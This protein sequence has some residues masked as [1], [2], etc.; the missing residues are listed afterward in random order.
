[1]NAPKVHIIIVNYGTPY[2]TLE[3]LD[4][5]VS[6]D[7][8][9]YQVI[10]VDVGNKNNSKK[11][12]GEWIEKKPETGFTLLTEKEN[13]GFAYANN[14]GIRYVLKQKDY[15][16]IWL[17]NNDTVIKEDSLSKLVECYYRY[18]KN[19]KVGFIGSKIVDYKERD[20]IQN[21]GGLFNK[22]TGYSVLKGLDEK[23]KGQFD[24]DDLKVDYI[25]GASMFF[26]SSLINDTGLMPE[27]YFLYYEDVEWCL[28]AKHA[29]FVNISC[30]NSVVFHK[31]GVST[32]T[33]LITNESF[34]E[35][36]KYL[37][38]SYILLYK[39]NFRSLLPIAYFILFKHFAGRI[40]HGNYKEA[41]MILKVIF[42]KK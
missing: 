8:D 4:S 38:S 35:N 7:Y 2:D 37:Y 27:D 33:K 6:N 16:F 23:D 11:I 17:L 19:K 25:V 9:N 26:H 3:C 22:W 24:T 42:N 30:N 34:N 28:K 1:M 36:K 29:G 13:K 15:D 12:I 41:K 21:V 5:V 32:G 18:N 31:Q 10:I 39:R 40:Y 20:L 14:I